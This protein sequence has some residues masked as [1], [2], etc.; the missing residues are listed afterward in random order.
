MKIFDSLFDGKVISLNKKFAWTIM[1]ISGLLM[2]GGWQW[3]NIRDTAASVFDGKSSRSVQMVGD[4]TDITGGP[5]LTASLLPESKK[6]V[7]RFN[8]SR[9]VVIDLRVDEWSQ[10][11]ITPALP[12]KY[13]DY[14]IDVDP[15]NGYLVKF[16]DGHVERVVA[17]QKAVTDHGMRRGIFRILAVSPGQKATVTVSTRSQ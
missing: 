8:E 11:L 13:V 16:Q 6:P 4:T 3:N 10:Q 17:D 7:I 14:R 2:L 12:N 15:P 1:L 5:P 9:Q